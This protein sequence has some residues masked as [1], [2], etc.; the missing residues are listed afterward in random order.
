MISHGS[1]KCRLTHRPLGQDKILLSPWLW[2]KYQ[3]C[4][5]T[6]RESRLRSK[7]KSFQRKW[8]SRDIV[9]HKRAFHEVCPADSSLQGRE[10]EA[11]R[12]QAERGRMERHCT[13]VPVQVSVECRDK[14]TCLVC[15][16]EIS[17]P[18]Q[19]LRT[20]RL[21]G[22]SLF[23]FLNTQLLNSAWLTNKCYK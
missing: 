4:H 3:R 5:F 18:A 10:T 2:S 9:G 12:S 19:V 21:R 7:T 1:G 20:S 23:Y 22:R 6:E 17:L 14:H 13:H 11:R 16:S 8:R 15:Y